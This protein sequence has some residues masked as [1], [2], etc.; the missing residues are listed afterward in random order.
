MVLFQFVSLLKFVKGGL[1]SGFK[2]S[3]TGEWSGVKN[4][5]SKMLSVTRS[6]NGDCNFSGLSLKIVFLN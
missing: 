1:W 4:V 6:V 2:V 5:L 3:S